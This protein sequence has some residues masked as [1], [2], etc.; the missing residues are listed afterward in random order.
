MREPPSMSWFEWWAANLLQGSVGALIGLLGLFA[1]FWFTVRHER[2]LERV[3]VAED[4]K[5]LERQHTAVSVA[6]VVKASHAFRL[7]V[8]LDR[9]ARTEALASALILMTVREAATHPKASDWAQRES[10]RIIELAYPSV[11]IRAAT[12]EAGLI[13]A[14]LV[15]W[16]AEGFTDEFRFP[17]VRLN[18]DENVSPERTTAG[19]QADPDEP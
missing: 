3:R 12:W 7:P 17:P 19:R 2:A 9:H 4:D 16:A 13:A 15:G 5:R 18:D 10:R 1:V 14:L 11:D 6:E 8:D